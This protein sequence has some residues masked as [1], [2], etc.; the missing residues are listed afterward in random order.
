[1]GIVFSNAQNIAGNL[2]TSLGTNSSVPTQQQTTD[3]TLGIPS[4]D[5]LTA[6]TSGTTPGILKV[7]FI[8]VGQADSILIQSEKAN[9]LID[10][11]NNDDG[12][13]VVNYLKSQGVTELTAVIATHPHED[14]IGGL[15]TVIKAFPP[16]TVYMPNVTSNTKTFE[17]FIAAVNKSGAKKIQAKA[18]VALN[19]SGISGIFL[20]PV[21]SSY[22][23]LN[24]YSAVLKL[25]YGNTSFLFTGDAEE[26]S[27]TEML[28]N[29]NLQATVLKVG[30]HGSSNATS[31]A[32]LKAVSPKYAVISVGKDNSY[33]HPNAGTL[34]KLEAAGVAI[35]RTD[36]VG[37]IIMTSDGNT[38]KVNKT[39]TSTATTATTTVSSSNGVKIDN[40]DLVGEIITLKNT[41]KSAVDLTGWKLFSEVG[42]QTYYFPNGTTISAGGELQIISGSDAIPSQGQLLWEKSNIWNNKGDQGKLYDSQG[43]LV[44][45]S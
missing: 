9:I 36:K 32:F 6:M 30:H 19:I 17:S 1:M 40:I 12:S 15:D 7:H 38:I 8:D 11:G 29:G 44:S 34:N 26:Q 14:H 27:E 2:A 28:K 42:D 41:S 4:A 31:P 10:G 33:N 25:T 3:Q 5:A 21:G 39:S 22:E 18:N 23:S 35:Y 37:T 45:Q 43:N 24:N 13:T 16:K 20:G